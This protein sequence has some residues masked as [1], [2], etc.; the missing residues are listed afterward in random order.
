[1]YRPA[2][3]GVFRQFIMSRPEAT[4]S[5]TKESSSKSDRLLPASVTDHLVPTL[6]F[7]DFF[8]GKPGAV[9]ELSRQLNESSEN[10]GFYFLKGAPEEL[11]RGLLPRVF[12]M[13]RRLHK[14]PEEKLRAI[15]Q[16]HDRQKLGYTFSDGGSKEG[17]S[18]AA[19]EGITP[20]FDHSKGVA[21][22]TYRLLSMSTGHGRSLAD[23]R[24]N[25]FPAESDLPGGF[26]V[27]EEFFAAMRA[28][29]F[30]I[31]PVYADALGMPEQDL[32]ARFT[33]A[34]VNLKF[35]YY[36]PRP[37]EKP[38]WNAI[39]AHC[40]VS[41]FT[42]VAQDGDD[43]TQ[44]GLQIM[45]PHGDWAGVSCPAD[46]ILVNTGEFLTRLTNGRWRNAVHKVIPPPDRDRYALVLFF[47][48]DKRVEMAP[49]PKFLSGPATNFQPFSY[50]SV[51]TSGETPFTV[52]LRELRKVR[53][54]VA[55][56][57][58]GGLNNSTEGSKL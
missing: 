50:H 46:C 12:E 49:L 6:D 44:P 5:E 35:Q 42:M 14:L 37:L 2:G 28:L 20:G 39:P 16:D 25:I 52:G 23:Q 43:P 1:M 22:G 26:E 27:T 48:Q 32:L 7:T 53:E 40:D 38:D 21:Q 11:V 30:S 31:L 9:E 18:Y 34:N 33:D 45:L 24:P 57:K 8:N 56:T 29:S 13:N 19:L 58:L 51:M 36:P 17:D 47:A 55:G 10:V 41:F 54:G 4:A 3:G 15:D